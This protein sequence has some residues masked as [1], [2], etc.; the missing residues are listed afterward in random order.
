MDKVCL[1]KGPTWASIA[2][3]LEDC[4]F[5]DKGER[6]F[7][8]MNRDLEEISLLL[9]KRLSRKA[10]LYNC[11]EDRGQHAACNGLR[12]ALR[13]GIDEGGRESRR[14]F[15]ADTSYLM[16]TLYVFSWGVLMLADTT[17]CSV[18]PRRLESILSIYVGTRQ[19]VVPF[20]GASKHGRSHA[21]K[22]CYGK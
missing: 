21:A 17:S 14:N 22:L 6:V 1:S 9:T 13:T 15:M 5:S 19:A 12:R 20:D 2:L 8:D 7:G 10:T 11:N 3:E 16:L 4:Q 18:C